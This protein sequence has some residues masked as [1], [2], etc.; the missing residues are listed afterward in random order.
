MSPSILH[1]GSAEGL[2]QSTG[3]KRSVLAART[4]WSLR[5]K[6]VSD[7]PLQ[8]V[9]VAGPKATIGRHPDNSL[10]ITNPTVSGRH[11]EISVANEKL[12]LTD[13]KSTNGT[14]H[15]GTRVT[16]TIELRDGDTVQFG[17]VALTLH[18]NSASP[19]LATIALS[20]A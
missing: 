12:Y 3:G 19:R 13:L 9:S 8:D 17:S 11:A 6:F 5:G 1:Y 7:G 20:A 15:N 18:R 16:E 14:F 2:D 10:C 4:Q